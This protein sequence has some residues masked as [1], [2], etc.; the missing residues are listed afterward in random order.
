[1]RTVDNMYADPMFRMHPD[2]FDHIDMVLEPRNRWRS[3]RQNVMNS[4]Y[5]SALPLLR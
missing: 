4:T 3:P 5:F 2:W 1:M